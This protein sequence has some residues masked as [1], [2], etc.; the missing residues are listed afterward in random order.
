MS[1]ILAACVLA[2]WLTPFAGF[3]AL[4]WQRNKAEQRVKELEAELWEKPKRKNTDYIWVYKEVAPGV[5]SPPF[6]AKVANFPDPPPDEIHLRLVS[7]NMPE[8]RPEPMQSDTIR[9]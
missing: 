3:F 5:Y 6:R 1:E 2:M 9:K 4:L 7:D 8:E